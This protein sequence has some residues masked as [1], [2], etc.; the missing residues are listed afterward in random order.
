MKL[1]KQRLKDMRA[2]L[3]DATDYHAHS[4]MF[5]VQDGIDLLDVVEKLRDAL[6]CY[7]YG[8]GDNGR[9]ARIVLL[10]VF[11]ESEGA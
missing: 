2:K 9:E 10:E 6:K 1:T 5:G 8:A 11:S 4:C 7:G 3:M